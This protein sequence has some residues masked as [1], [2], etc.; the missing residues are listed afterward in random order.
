MAVLPTCKA[1]PDPNRAS[2]H[3][4]PDDLDVWKGGKSSAAILGLGFAT[5]TNDGEAAMVAVVTD[6]DKNPRR[7]VVVVVVVVVVKCC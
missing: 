7:D 1:V 2:D 5:S 6:L 3:C 4:N